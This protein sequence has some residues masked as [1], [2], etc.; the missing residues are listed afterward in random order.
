MNMYP[1]GL[2][3]L[4][5]ALLTTPEMTRTASSQNKDTYD[6]LLVAHE[7]LSVFARDLYDDWDSD[8]ITISDT[9]E[10]LAF[11]TTKISYHSEVPLIFRNTIL[12]RYSSHTGIG[13]LADFVIR[14]HDTSWVVRFDNYHV[15]ENGSFPVDKL[16]DILNRM[17][18][19]EE[20]RVYTPQELLKIVKTMIDIRWYRYDGGA[21]IWDKNAKQISTFD[22]ASLASIPV[23]ALEEPKA[24]SSSGEVTLSFTIRGLMPHLQVGV[25]A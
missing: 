5:V 24:I 11:A 16:L 15:Q 14:I 3:I 13:Y 22:S 9:A 7:H 21:F 17:T 8:S 2:V 18:R 4:T 12:R 23:Y 10:V 6:L 25:I 1:A 19:A 20:D